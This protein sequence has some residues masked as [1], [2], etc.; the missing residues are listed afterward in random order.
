MNPFLFEI[1][2]GRSDDFS[3]QLVTYLGGRREV[4]AKSA[5]DWDTAGAARTAADAMK[6]AVAA[7]PVVTA[8]PQPGD[9][10]FEVLQDVLPL[11]VTGHGD[12]DGNG[13]HPAAATAPMPVT[14]IAVPAGNGV[15]R[16]DSVQQTPPEPAAPVAA[17]PATA[18]AETAP[19]AEAANKAS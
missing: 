7:A 17:L 3:W 13:G 1:V 2:R 5:A 12:H 15:K 19:R 6:K 16:A 10:R 11:H 4:I 9:I 18:P 8:P 14:S